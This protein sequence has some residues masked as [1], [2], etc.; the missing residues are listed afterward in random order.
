[1]LQAPFT[2]QGEVATLGAVSVTIV[3]TTAT[4]REERTP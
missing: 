4:C 1:L 3:H 2:A